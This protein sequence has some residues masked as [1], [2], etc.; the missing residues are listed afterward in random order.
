MITASDDPVE[1]TYQ[2]RYELNFSCAEIAA[3]LGI[4]EGTVVSR[5]ARARKRHGRR[6]DYLRRSIGRERN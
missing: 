5:L 1:L 2:L 6:A 4:P 3:Y